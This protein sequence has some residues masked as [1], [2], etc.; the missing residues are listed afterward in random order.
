MDGEIHVMGQVCVC[1]CNINYTDKHVDE[2]VYIKSMPQL[3]VT[4]NRIFTRTL[5]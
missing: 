4:I 2:N 1:V 3:I 5:I